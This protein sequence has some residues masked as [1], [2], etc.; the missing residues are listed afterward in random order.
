MIAI[1]VM[2]LFVMFMIGKLGGTGAFSASNVYSEYASPAEVCAENGCE[3][4]GH[5]FPEPK[6]GPGRVDCQCQG[7]LKTF[8]LVKKKDLN[9][10]YAY[11]Q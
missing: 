5:V 11:Y 1:V 9:R 8:Q 3:Y 7:E 6:F 4:V 10:Y 2:V